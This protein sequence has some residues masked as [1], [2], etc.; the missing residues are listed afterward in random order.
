MKEI[1]ENEAI[2]IETTTSDNKVY[3]YQNELLVY[4]KGKLETYS[5]YGKKTWEYTFEET[6]IPEITTVKLN[7]RIIRV[8]SS[9]L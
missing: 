7:T 3:A 5:R 4:S 9:L 2:I 1:S 6:F 8:N